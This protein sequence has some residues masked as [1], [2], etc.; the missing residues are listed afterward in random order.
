MGKISAVDKD[1][2]MLRYAKEHL[3]A[4]QLEKTEDGGFKL[5]G[6]YVATY[7]NIII[8]P[9]VYTEGDVDEAKGEIFAEIDPKYEP[10]KKYRA[11]KLIQAVEGCEPLIAKN[12]AKKFM[13]IAAEAEPVK[14]EL[15]PS[16]L[17]APEGYVINEFGIYAERYK[18]N[19]LI[20]VEVNRTLYYITERIKDLDTD[21][22]R[23]NICY[24]RDNRTRNI[25]VDAYN[26]ATKKNIT[27]LRKFGILVNDT[28]SKDNIKWLNDFEAAN[29]NTLPIKR[30]VSR[31]GW[32]SNGVFIPYSDTELVFF[33]KATGS[34]E[35][36]GYVTK[37]S[38]EEWVQV[39]RGIEVNY[40]ARALIMASASAPFLKLINQRP[41]YL[42]NW[43]D[44]G[45]G[46]TAGL[47]FAQSVWGNPKELM[48]NYNT[49]TVGFELMAEQRNDLPL[50]MNERQVV[51]RGD[52]AQ[53]QMEQGV[54]MAM[55]GTGR[56]RA[57]KDAT[58]RD[59][60]TWRSIVIG[61]GEQPLIDSNTPDGVS[62]RVIE[63]NGV[64]FF[65]EQMARDTYEVV[66]EH[67]G[68]L[69]ERIVKSLL[70]ADNLE[71]L[72][73]SLKSIK[74]RALTMIKV[75]YADRKESILDYVAYLVAI[76][77]IIHTTLIN[78][79]QSH[80]HA[81]E[82]AINNLAFP[83]LEGQA[84][85]KESDV[86]EKFYANVNDW[87]NIN[88]NKFYKLDK[89]NQAQEKQPIRKKAIEYDYIPSGE[90]WGLI[91][92]G[93]GWSSIYVIPKVFENYCN[94][95]QQNKS[96]MLKAFAEKG[97]IETCIESKDNKKVVRNTIQKKINNKKSN[98][99][100]FIFEDMPF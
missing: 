81:F 31:T 93:E 23:L 45:G 48:V 83:I 55:E 30:S 36:K 73:V 87:L 89:T 53:S 8:Y 80:E 97:Y 71:P 76:D 33:N 42:Y 47:V 95:E 64:P 58:L 43:G 98:C 14:H 5:Q 85:R 52:K 15:L 6:C 28:N 77:V 99:I 13:E 38:F 72:T 82:D 10:W 100:K 18:Y 24:K 20:E 91:E 54:Y 62:T 12:R 92:Q 88:Q 57:K 69:G 3:K 84:T 2:D 39:M 86:T 16:G 25:I 78:A 79:N 29:Y 75:K 40:I 35:L 65:N 19:Q 70:H 32:Q 26:I 17:Y 68:V 59:T 63:L 22:E 94:Q 67:Y 9:K 61:N 60:K 27:S 21:E 51:G 66:N 74:A 34:R 4:Q 44:S 49:T 46:K 11:T 37:G 50:C 41:F 7:N 96:K 56:V 1:F 90:I